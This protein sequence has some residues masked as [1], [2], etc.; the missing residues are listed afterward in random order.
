MV[1]LNDWELV[2]RAQSGDMDGFAQLVRRYQGPLMQFC[3]RML[4]SVQDGEEVAQDAFVRVYRHLPRL[5]PQARFSTF[6]FGVARN[7]VLNAIRDAGR[8]DRGRMQTFDAPPEARDTGRRPDQAARVNEIESLL[9]QCLRLL[10]PEHREILIL[11]EMNGLDYD[12]I[13]HVIQCE[14]GTVK[15]RLAR[16]REQLRLQLE[17]HGGQLL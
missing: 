1:E 13:A 15:S 12:N 14:K 4:G 6:L 17:I 16:A 10:S 7:L 5:K 3:S 8:R 2:A 9:Q 11:R